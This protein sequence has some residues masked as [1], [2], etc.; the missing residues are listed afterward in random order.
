MKLNIQ[1]RIALLQILPA[2]GDIV[3][4][5]VLGDMQ[6]AIGF[7]EETIKKYDIVTKDQRVTW[8]TKGVEE[9]EIELGEK[10]SEIIKEALLKLDKE[11][12][13]N[14]SQITIYEKFVQDKVEKE[15]KK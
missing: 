8:N 7:S 3:T 11:K 14:G 4:L 5:R 12:K 1:E 9:T 10:A 15:E 6:K 2:E 13:L